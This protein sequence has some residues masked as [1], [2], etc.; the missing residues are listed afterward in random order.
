MFI[1]HLSKML[2]YFTIDFETYKMDI[3]FDFHESLD[4]LFWGVFIYLTIWGV[5]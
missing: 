4:N 3:T 1:V 5:Y 2:I